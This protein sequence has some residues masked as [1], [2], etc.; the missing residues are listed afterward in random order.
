MARVYAA[1]TVTLN[2]RTVP[3]PSGNAGVFAT[4]RAM[5]ELVN[6]RKADPRIIQAA[7]SIIWCAPERD[8]LCEVEALHAYV[9]D[10]IRYVRDPHALE[11]LTDPAL[12]LAR[13]VGDC[14][15]QAALL[16]A[17]LESVGYPTRFV[18]AA[19]AHPGAWD[20]VWLQVYAAGQWIDADP[21]E[22]EPLGWQPPAPLAIW[23]EGER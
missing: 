1:P 16:A 7:T 6:A 17:L 5:R 12:T 10:S 4:I 21:T 22:H 18:I 13:R 23:I 14:D 15:D 20:H 11:S 19:F 3:V 9:R 2:A 8:E